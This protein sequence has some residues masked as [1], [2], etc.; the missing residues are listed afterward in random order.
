[1]VADHTEFERISDDHPPL[2]TVVQY[3]A[4]LGCL[5]TLGQWALTGLTGRYTLLSWLNVH[6]F[7]R[8][9]TCVWL[10][11]HS[12]PLSLNGIYMEFSI[13]EGCVKISGGPYEFRSVK[14][15]RTWCPKTTRTQL[16]CRCLFSSPLLCALLS[17]SIAL[18]SVDYTVHVLWKWRN[19]ANLR[20][21]HGQSLGQKKRNSPC[22]LP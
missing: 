14:H 1:M 19:C 9:R 8:T 4:Y 18:S 13:S 17:S 21:K 11:V 20:R 16:L 6:R 10:A 5:G 3:R 15:S 22:H 12:Y 7:G 2:H